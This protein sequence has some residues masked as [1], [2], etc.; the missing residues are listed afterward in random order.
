[1]K[2]EIPTAIAYF[3]TRA[4]QLNS[5]VNDMPLWMIKA[6]IDFAR[7]HCEAQ[8]KKIQNKICINDELNLVFL[9]DKNAILN[10]YP[11]AN[12]K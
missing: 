3:K 4:N 1:M 6:S 7:I 9:A 11:L 8:A 5:D 2:E 12:I 10:A